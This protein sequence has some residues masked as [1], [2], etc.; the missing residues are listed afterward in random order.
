MCFAIMYLGLQKV[1]FFSIN[2]ARNAKK[3]IFFVDMKIKAIQV[4]YISLLILFRSEL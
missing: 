3:G 4:L 1:L 2:S